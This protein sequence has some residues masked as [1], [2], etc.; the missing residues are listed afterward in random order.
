LARGRQAGWFFVCVMEVCLP[1][2][3]VTST[4]GRVE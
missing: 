1:S 2:A 4:V 3:A